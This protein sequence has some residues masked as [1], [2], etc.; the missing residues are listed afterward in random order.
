MS[1]NLRFSLGLI[2]LFA[3]LLL[4]AADVTP[5]SVTSENRINDSDILAEYDGGQISREDIKTKISKL[6]ANY[7]GRYQT[8]DGQIEVLNITATEEAFYQKAK[9]MG[10]DKDPSVLERIAGVE[11]RFYIQEYY[12]RNVSDLVALTDADMQEFYQQNLGVFF[13]NPYISIDYIQVQDEAEGKKAL[14]ELKKG[15][16]FNE[17]SDKYNQNVYAKG[18]LGKVKNIRLNGNIPGVGNDAELEALIGKSKVD[19]QNYIGPVQTSTGWHIFRTT[20]FVEGRQK[21]FAEVKPEIEQRLRPT[22]ER[23]LL[24]A[25]VARIKLTYGVVIDSSMVNVI[26]LKNRDLNR[27]IL[28][29]LIVNSTKENLR[30]SVRQILDSFDK[31]PPQDQVFILKGG[32]VNQLIDSELIQNLLYEEAKANAYEQY[33]ADNED[34]RAMKRSYILRKAFELLV[35]NTIEVSDQEIQNR[36]ELDLEQYATPA[37]RSIEVLFFENKKTADKAWRKYNSAYKKKN[38]KKMQAVIAKYSQKADTSL[39]DFQYQNGVVTGIGN[40]PE[41]SNLI[42]NN[43]VGYLSPVF[44]AARGDIVFFRTLS[45]TPKSYKPLVEAS[46]RIYGLI[47]KD[48]EKSRQDK[49]TEELFVEFNMRKY[50]ERV[51]L[52]LTAEELFTQADDAA[53]QRN[54]K[55]AIVFYDQIITTYRN[56][57]DDYKASFMKAFLIAEEMKENDRALQMFK[58]FLKQYPEGDLNESA[59]FMIDSLEG[60][61]PTEIEN[62]EE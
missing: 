15:T 24:N 31:I 56:G 41:F 9:Q 40:D 52:L 28:D 34:Y 60:K 32:G 14:A 62:I 10:L 55:D 38:E 30:L 49:V 11:K 46:P 25:V 44:T 45:E 27:D 47:K 1:N 2:F 35:V 22:K 12:K 8:V 29:N 36:Y 21:E 53:R 16:P 18:L 50:P 59:Q 19:D 43:P 20:E 33:F 13:L 54:F 57:N 17:V 61:I 58:D 23:D 6:P 4:S 26:D 5:V 7:Q 3:C 42:W 48:K 37:H 39:F 51:R